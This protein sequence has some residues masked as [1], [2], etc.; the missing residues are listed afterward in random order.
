MRRPILMRKDRVLFLT[1][2][3]KDLLDKLWD[4]SQ[5]VNKL[6]EEL[7]AAR[8]R[9]DELIRE[10]RRRRFLI[11][12]IGEITGLS[13]AGVHHISQEDDE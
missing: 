3:D 7:L 8:G 4:E 10:A 5:K 1:A 6:E 13:D 2:E 11:R 9:R 12:E